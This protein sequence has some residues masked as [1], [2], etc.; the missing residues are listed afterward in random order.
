MTDTL[1]FLLF[2]IIMIAS[3]TVALFSS[4][5]IVIEKEACGPAITLAISSCVG[6]VVTL[7][8]GSL[9]GI[10][11]VPYVGGAYFGSVVLATILCCL[12]QIKQNY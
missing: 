4:L 10:P 9:S 6:F 3:A 8:F 11:W 1:G 2:L 12:C 7:P 5:S